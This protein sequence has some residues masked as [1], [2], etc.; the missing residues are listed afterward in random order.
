[1]YIELEIFFLTPSNIKI[2]FLEQK[3]NWRL[4]TTIEDLPTIKRVELVKKKEFVAAA[5][6]L[7]NK[8]F[9]VY[10]AFFTNTNL[11]PSCIAKITLLI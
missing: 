5:L 10:L 8:T 4:Y 7:D 11:Y 6:D 1:M 2:N 9:M 3:L